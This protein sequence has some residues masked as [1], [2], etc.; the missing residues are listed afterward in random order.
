MKNRI[1]SQ[2][3]ALLIQDVL[4][5]STPIRWTITHD[6]YALTIRATEGLRERSAVSYND[7]HQVIKTI[8]QI[9]DGLNK[10]NSEDE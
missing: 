7:R 9:A 8:G 2:G 1:I 3:G 10:E 6:S 4:N 5:A